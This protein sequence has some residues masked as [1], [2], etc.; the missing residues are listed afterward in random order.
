MQS[1][2][3]NYFML[4]SNLHLDFWQVCNFVSL[5][6]L[7][8]LYT[9]VQIIYENTELDWTLDWFMTETTWNVSWVCLTFNKYCLHKVFSCLF[10]HPFRISVRPYYLRVLMVLSLGH[11][12]KF[13]FIKVHRIYH[14]LHIPYFNKEN[15]M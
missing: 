7:H 6:N 3:L 10:N 4:I 14:C 5:A 15:F 9:I 13:Q 11:R 2:T 8:H 12:Q 1:F